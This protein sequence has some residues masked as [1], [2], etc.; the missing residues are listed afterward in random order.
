MKPPTVIVVLANLMTNKGKPNAETVARLDLAAKIDLELRSDVIM[1]C[2]WAYR[3][4]CSLTIADAMKTYIQTQFPGLGERIVCQRLSRDTVGDA[5][6]TRLYL[7]E[8]F[9]G[10]SPVNLNV[11]TSDYHI[12]RV[13]EVFKFV[14]GVSSLIS[15]KGV[16]TLNSDASA[17][18]EMQ[19]LAAFRKTFA[20]SS[21]GDL[22]SIYFCLRR[23][24]PLYNG[25]N[26]QRIEEMSEVLSQI[27]SSLD[28]L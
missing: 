24:H 28:S 6:F 7:R 9:T 27:K 10:R 2:G 23:N 17:A 25:T 11:I 13:N 16:P 5:I 3:P 20:D 21:A 18:K 19:S 15:I 22:N 8:L 1:L 26:Y 14:F 12:K 4:D